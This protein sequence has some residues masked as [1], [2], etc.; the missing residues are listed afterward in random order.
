MIPNYLLTIS[1]F[2][3]MDHCSLTGLNKSF[4]LPYNLFKLVWV[5]SNVNQYAETFRGNTSFE[6]ITGPSRLPYCNT[7]FS[8]GELVANT[9]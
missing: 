1:L 7:T 8:A 3:N 5:M 4:L 2:S 9:R 6:R